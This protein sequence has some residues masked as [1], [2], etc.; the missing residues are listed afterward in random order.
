MAEF[1]MEIAGCSGRVRTLFD[2][3]R[4]YCRN[5]L[6]E[7]EPAFTVSV[8]RDDLLFEQ[9]ELDAEADAEGMKR[10]C[11]SD[12]FLERAAIQ[13]AFAERLFDRG[14]LLVHG[15][16][17]AVDGKGY[18]FTARCGTGKSTHTRLWR[19]TFGN[20]ARMVNDDKP[21]VTLGSPVMVCGAPWSGKHGL[22]SNITV[23][24][25]GICILER[26]Q[27]NR[28]E[29]IRPEEAAPLLRHQSYCPMDPGKEEAFRS[30]TDKLL[31]NVPLWRIF[32]T[33]DPQAARIAFDAMSRP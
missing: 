8:T 31:K 7:Q 33:K 16:T 1:I 32:C 19:E 29:R 20:R 25:Q 6:T 10:R 14:I 13:R 23:P 26:G 15:S 2:S 22:D 27:E 3:T 28:I 4:D 17:V 5:Y 21:F 12:P 24:L 30:L 11:F 9:Q 18:L